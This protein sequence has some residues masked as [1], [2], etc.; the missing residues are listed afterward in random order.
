MRRASMALLIALG[1]AASSWQTWRSDAAPLAS[2]PANGADAQPGLLA[3]QDALDT[4]DR[5]SR[6]DA[7]ANGAN[8]AQ[9]PAVSS[10]PAPRRGIATEE[11]ATVAA[12]RS[13]LEAR[14][15]ALSDR[16]EDLLAEA[17]VVEARRHQLDPWLV[18]AVIQVES[19]CYHL[20]VSPVG[21]IG[22]MQL[23][24]A[25]AEEVA[26]RNDVAWHGDDTLY[27]PV[28]NVKLGTA[29]LKDLSRRF[30]SVSTALAAYN[31]GPGRI[32]SRLR[33]GDGVPSL[34]IGQVMEAYEKTPQRL[35]AN[36]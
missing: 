35:A 25:T 27:D 17:I 1:I 10:A 29:Y 6:G 33:K 2:A 34:Y 20:A 23:L 26:R 36:S 30:G 32:R 16:D 7:A 11:R 19:Q 9:L 4:L 15:T 28:T 24:P 3:T 22:L 31:W 5:M 14:H 18:L 12:I 13:F 21:A 8:L